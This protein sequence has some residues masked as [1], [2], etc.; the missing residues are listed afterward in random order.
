MRG[1]GGF[2]PAPPRLD[3]PAALS[4]RG[5]RWLAPAISA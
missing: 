4:V 3:Q 2:S 5:G 1:A